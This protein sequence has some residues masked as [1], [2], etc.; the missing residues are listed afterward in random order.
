MNWSMWF[1]VSLNILVCG[2]GIKM[3]WRTLTRPGPHWKFGLGIVVAGIAIVLIGQIV[4]VGIAKCGLEPRGQ[5]GIAIISVGVAVLALGAA[6]L[7]QELGRGHENMIRVTAC[8]VTGIG[9]V[10]FLITL[11]AYLIMTYW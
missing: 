1:I 3:V 5:D 9:G 7:F 8:S 2:L 4:F 10:G 11:V 6:T